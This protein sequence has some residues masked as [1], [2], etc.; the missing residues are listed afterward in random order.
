MRCNNYI[1]GY[2]YSGNSAAAVT[3]YLRTGTTVNGTHTKIGSNVVFTDTGAKT[4]YF[5]RKAPSTATATKVYLSF[6][7]N[8]T[9]LGQ[10]SGKTN[11]PIYYSSGIDT[12]TW[13]LF[14]GG[15]PTFQAL[16]TTAKSW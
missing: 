10:V 4:V 8:G 13:S 9:A 7:T 12:N 6:Y 1:I 15:Y 3:T 14:T 2:A 5:I 11:Y 16:A